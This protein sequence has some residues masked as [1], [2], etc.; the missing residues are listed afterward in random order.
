MRNANQRMLLWSVF[1]VLAATLPGAGTAWAATAPP[2]QIASASQIFATSPTQLQIEGSGFGSLRPT[3]VLGGT[4][5][6]VLSFTDT[7]VFASIPAAVPD[8]AY[9]LV[10]TSGDP[11]GGSSAPFDVAIGAV[12]PAGPTGPAGPQGLADRRRISSLTTFSRTRAI[13]FC[14]EPQ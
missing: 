10:L 1:T 14:G 6:Y 13:R 4:P 12:G 9:A 7:L 5:L 8:G 2:P 11:K 3:V